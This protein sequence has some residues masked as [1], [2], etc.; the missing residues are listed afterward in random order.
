MRNS[1]DLTRLSPFLANH[2]CADHVEDVPVDI[3][4]NNYHCAWNILLQPEKFPKANFS[5]CEKLVEELPLY[6]LELI[7]ENNRLADLFDRAKATN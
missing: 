6:W 7:T 4:H 5:H 3:A 1:N 2:F